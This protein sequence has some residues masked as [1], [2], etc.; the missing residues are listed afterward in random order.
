MLKLSTNYDFNE[1]FLSQ[2]ILDTGNYGIVYYYFSEII[3]MDLTW[4]EISQDTL[5]WAL[6]QYNQKHKRWWTG[7]SNT[8]SFCRQIYTV[9]QWWLIILLIIMLMVNYSTIKLD[10][11][12]WLVY[13]IYNISESQSQTILFDVMWLVYWY[14][15][16]IATYWETRLKNSPIQKTFCTFF[17][18]IQI[19]FLWELFPFNIGKGLVLSYGV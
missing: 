17:H 9:A 16:C 5:K 11:Y 18:L 8:G 12:S 6:I 2:C 14:S 10:W 7:W 3:Q 19:L 15:I 4:T 13:L 1:S